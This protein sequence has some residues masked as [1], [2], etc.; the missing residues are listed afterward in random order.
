MSAMWSVARGMT[1]GVAM[2]EPRQV[3]EED[4]SV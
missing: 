3:V 2:R 4:A 1:S